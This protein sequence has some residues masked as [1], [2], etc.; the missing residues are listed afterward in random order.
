MGWMI[1]KVFW[2]AG[3][4]QEGAYVSH[5]DTILGLYAFGLGILIAYA[6]V[7]GL[8]LQSLDETDPSSLDG[9]GHR[10]RRS[11][12]TGRGRRKRNKNGNDASGYST[13]DD[14]WEL[15]GRALFPDQ[16]SKTPPRP[17]S[18]ASSQEEFVSPTWQTRNR[19]A[20]GLDT[21]THNYFTRLKR[22][23]SRG[24]TAE[25]EVHARIERVV[26]RGDTPARVFVTKR[27]RHALARYNA[28]KAY[29]EGRLGK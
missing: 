11:G 12:G 28:R 16:H 29:E 27:Q 17:G 19:I 2:M 21:P 20:R 18:S 9:S 3:W 4:S 14:E 6:F 22:L 15:P 7:V 10:K 23:E 25:S 1:D 13:S 5:D 8:R 24:N 26:R